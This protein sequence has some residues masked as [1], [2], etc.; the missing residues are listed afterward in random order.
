MHWSSTSSYR[1]HPSIHPGIGIDGIGGKRKIHSHLGYTIVM[2][3][4]FPPL[5]IKKMIGAY[6]GIVHGHLCHA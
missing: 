6:L 1:N 4:K 5:W 3:L 2:L